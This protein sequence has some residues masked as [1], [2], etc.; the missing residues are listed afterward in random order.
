LKSEEKFRRVVS[1]KKSCHIGFLIYNRL[2]PES[3]AYSRLQKLNVC[4][5]IIWF[6]FFFKMLFIYSSVTSGF[7]EICIFR[8]GGTVLVK[9][10]NLIRTKWLQGRF[11]SGTMKIKHHAMKTWET[12]GLT[13]HIL[14]LISSWR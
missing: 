14:S 5:N 12:R 4:N 8:K 3:L 10:H 11:K 13:P 7:G 1:G 9:C 6:F 2:I